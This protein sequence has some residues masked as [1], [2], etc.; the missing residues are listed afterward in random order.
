MELIGYLLGLAV[1]GL[2][3]G[4]LGRLLVPGPDPMGLAGTILIG[5]AGSFVAGI[6]AWAFWESATPG[7]ILSVLVT[8]LLV[9]LIRPRRRTPTRV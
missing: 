4:A 7:F 6:V 1:I 5:L 3:V 8:A 2:V 9:W